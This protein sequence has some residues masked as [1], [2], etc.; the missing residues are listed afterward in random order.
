MF[1]SVFVWRNKIKDLL[2]SD[3]YDVNKFQF[4]DAYMNFMSYILGNPRFLKL[5]YDFPVVIS[6][7]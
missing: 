2:P 6:E 5:D 1:F 3:Y 7:D 4:A